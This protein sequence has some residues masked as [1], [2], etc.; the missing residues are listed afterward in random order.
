MTSSPKQMSAGR[1]RQNTFTS[2]DEDT[3]APLDVMTLDDPDILFDRLEGSAKDLTKWL[4]MMETSLEDILA[5]VSTLEGAQTR[6]NED[7]LDMPP[8]HA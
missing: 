8:M 7:T 6:A 2:L 3:I 5:P 4:R 1:S